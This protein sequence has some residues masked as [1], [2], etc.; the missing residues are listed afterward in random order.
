MKF[1]RNGRYLLSFTAGSGN[2]FNITHGVALAPRTVDDF[3]VFVADRDNSRVQAFTS[4]GIFR[5]FSVSH[6]P[7]DKYEYGVIY[8]VNG[9]LPWGEAEVFEI[10]VT[11]RNW[12]LISSFKTSPGSV[13]PNGYE[14]PH[15]IIASKD[16]KSIYVVISI[17]DSL[18]L[19]KYKLVDDGSGGSERIAFG[20]GG[21]VALFHFMLRF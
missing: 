1:D 7:S 9:Y 21:L 20:C 19:K 10:G 11:A 6:V 4:N 13:D 17:A 2:P 3:L 18:V 8:A 14:A 15:D 12:T 16:G 5:I